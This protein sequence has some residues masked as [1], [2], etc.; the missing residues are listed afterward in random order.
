ME[1]KVGYLKK[2]IIDLLKI[3]LKPGE[4]KLLSGGIKHIRKRRTN[5]FNSYINKIPDII[6]SPDYIG[7]NPKYLKSVEYIKKI[8]KNILV[9]VRLS[10]YGGLRGLSVATMY[11]ITESKILSMLS[12]DRIIKMK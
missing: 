10:H 1:I 12:Y 3:N 6:K 7:T 9:A 11:E 5:C 8:D 2:E 4:I